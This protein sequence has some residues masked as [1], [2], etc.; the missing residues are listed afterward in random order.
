MRF[1][2]SNGP[3]EHG[4]FVWPRVASKAL[5]AQPI[6]VDLGNPCPPSDV[7]GKNT[8]RTLDRRAAWAKLQ[9]ADE[10]SLASVARSE[11]V[12]IRGIGAVHES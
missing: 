1:A 2:S 9:G 3:F 7:V 11:S 12:L 6:A 4:G 10:D 8:D 5:P